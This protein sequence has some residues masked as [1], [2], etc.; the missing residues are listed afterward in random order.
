MVQLL[1]LQCCRRP[2]LLL[3]A[4]EAQPLLQ[5]Q[6][7]LQGGRWNSTITL[8]AYP[9]PAYSCCAANAGAAAVPTPAAAPPCLHRL[10]AQHLLRRKQ[11][12]GIH[13]DFVILRE[14]EKRLERV[15]IYK[16]D[17]KILWDF[18]YDN[19]YKVALV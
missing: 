13:H 3:A 2:G 9:L 19:M 1:L 12:P 11:C 14:S 4:F 16:R 7:L 18:C 10:H 6:L 8:P 17:E 15:R 5:L